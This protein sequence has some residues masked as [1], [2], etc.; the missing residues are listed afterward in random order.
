MESSIAKTDKLPASKDSFEAHGDEIVDLPNVHVLGH[1]A[2]AGLDD[3]LQK[4]DAFGVGVSDLGLF[5]VEE[6]LDV[7]V[8]YA[9]GEIGF[10]A[11]LHVLPQVY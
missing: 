2:V 6:S 5:L 7:T 8:N 10:E 3:R 4:T 1:H 9:L 11:L